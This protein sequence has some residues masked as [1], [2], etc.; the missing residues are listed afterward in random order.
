MTFTGRG[1]DGAQVHFDTSLDIDSW[2]RWET[3]DQSLFKWSLTIGRVHSC[4]RLFC[5]YSDVLLL[6]K[7]KIYW[8]QRVA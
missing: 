8:W 4:Q 1:M 5:E 7:D 6:S 2:V 3:M